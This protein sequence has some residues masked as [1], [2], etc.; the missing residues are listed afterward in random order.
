YTPGGFRNVS[1]QSFQ[2]KNSGP[3]VMTTRAQ[4]L[5]MYVVYDSPFACVSDSPSAYRGQT[6][7][8]F[9]KAVPTS[10]DETRVLAGKIGEYLV[11]ARRHGQDWYIG[12]MNNEQGREIILPLNFLGNGNY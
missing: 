8:Q 9:L 6:G 5:A 4:Q 2:I 7:A 12:A 1:S 10:W 11:I 3:Q